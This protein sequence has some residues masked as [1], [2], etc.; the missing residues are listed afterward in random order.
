MSF[1]LSVPKIEMMHAIGFYHQQSASDRDDYID[2]YL[3]NVK[4]GLE[5]NFVKYDSKTVTDFGVGYDYQSIMHYS[6]NAFSKNGKPT[7]LPKEGN[8][9]LGNRNGLT[10]KD[11]QKIAAMYKNVCKN[12]VSTDNA[13]NAEDAVNTEN[14]GDA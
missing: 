3:D 5:Y 12:A 13:E 10:D 6:K 8:F 1:F 2:L 11:I 7:M 9:E 4:D 14:P